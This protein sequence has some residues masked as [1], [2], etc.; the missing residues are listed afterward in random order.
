MF[1][2]KSLRV[3]N[4]FM[5]YL[6]LFLGLILI[7]SILGF[8]NSSSHQNDFLITTKARIA[9]EKAWDTYHHGALGGTLP[10]PAIQ[11]DLEMKL[12]RCRALL[13][14]AYE[15]EDKGDDVKAKQLIRKILEISNNVITE[16]QVPKK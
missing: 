12:H 9:V 2:C 16:S 13:A 11:T 14:E 8:K 10:S 1:T 5:N 15:A 6:K 3:D 7:I 4:L